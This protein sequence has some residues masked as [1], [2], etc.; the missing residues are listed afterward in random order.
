MYRNLEQFDKAIAMV[1]EA[2]KATKNI[3]DFPPEQVSFS[4]THTLS[5]SHTHTH[6]TYIPSLSLS[7]YVS[8]SF[9]FPTPPTSLSLSLSLIYQGLPAGTGGGL[10][11]AQRVLQGVGKVK[12]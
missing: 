5:L 10:A 3:K 2:V 9:T 7:F 11:A 1:D 8:L 4:H 6:T 12:P